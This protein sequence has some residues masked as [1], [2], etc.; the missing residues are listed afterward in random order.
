MKKL[1]HQFLHFAAVGL[2][3]TGIQYLT[4]WFGVE[5]LGAAAAV[6]SAV[7]YVFGCFANYALNYKYTFKSGKSHAEA[8]SKYFTI[9]GVGWCLNTL[10][11]TLFVHTLGWQYFIA[12]IITTGIGLIWNFGGSRFWA[13][14]E[15]R[16]EH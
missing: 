6:A 5:H 16:H 8:A 13:F 11:M 14:R 9:V 3:G 1:H 4:L 12:Q 15:Q 7:G 2:A 10:L